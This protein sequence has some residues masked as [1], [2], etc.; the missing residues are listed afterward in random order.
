MQLPAG[1]LL[2][3]IPYLSS[4]VSIRPDAD[5]HQGPLL[6]VSIADLESE[7]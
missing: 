1:V 5:A 7:N 3:V 6:E 4:A 2:D